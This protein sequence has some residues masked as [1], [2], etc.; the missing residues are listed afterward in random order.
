M[1]GTVFSPRNGQSF[2]GADAQ[3][4]AIRAHDL[5]GVLDLPE[6]RTGVD[7]RDGMRTKQEARHDAEISAAA[8]Q[9]PEQ[10]RVLALARRDQPA[11]GEHDVRFQQVVDREP[12]HAAQVAAA[13]AERETGD[14]GR[15]NDARRNCEA[16]CMR[17]MI[18]VA[19]RAA[20]FDANRAR[21]RVDA[22]SLEPTEIDHDAAVAAAETGAVV[23]AAANRDEQIVIAREIHR[24]D[25]VR[26][27]AASCDDV[28]AVSGSSRCRAGT[29]A[30]SGNRS[31]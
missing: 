29:P 19:L 14:A 3:E 20:G 17:G 11:V 6:D 4:L 27:V 25:D 23:A 16:E 10:I 8:A 31:Q 26:H 22:N 5:R 12:V 13:A 24:R 18:H 15:R 9:R 1:E 7:V 21:R 28:A 2:S 30:R